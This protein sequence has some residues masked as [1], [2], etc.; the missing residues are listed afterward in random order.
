[1]NKEFNIDRLISD[2]DFSSNMLSDIGNGIMLTN[3]E[4]DVLNRYQID[5]KS[6]LNLKE[7]IYK[8]EDVIE[9]EEDDID[10]LD[11]VSSTI[12]ERDYYQ[13]TNK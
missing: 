6:C 3:R 7:I 12:A 13:N 10:E 4:I 9:N 5:Y 8:I 2:M 1:M 11:Y